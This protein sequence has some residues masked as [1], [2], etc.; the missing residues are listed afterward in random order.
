MPYIIDGN[1][2][3]GSSPDISLDDKDSRKKIIYILKKYQG[4]KNNNI[5][6]VFDGE[7]DGTLNR[8]SLKN[9]FTI[10]YPKYGDSADDEIK[11]IIDN[12]TNLKDVILVSSDRELK[13]CAK[14]KGARTINSIEFYFELK[15]V[16]HVNGKKEKLKKRINIKIS[17]KE[18]DS[19]MKI[20]DKK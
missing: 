20:F 19:W 1:N 18:V 11:K 13:T 10:V 2:L 3:I 14:K 17:E 5:I 15:R 16:Y 6:V 9:K 4:V 8:E 7:P 12:Y